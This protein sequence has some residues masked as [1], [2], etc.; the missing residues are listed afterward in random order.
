MKFYSR[1]VSFSKFALSMFIIVILVFLVAMPLVMKD[2]SG[3]RVAFS[4][5]EQTDDA[6]PV[7]EKPQFQGVDKHNRPYLITAKTAQQSG[8]SLILL[9]EVMADVTTQQNEW[10]ALKAKQG[11]LNPE[12]KQLL[13]L[14][15]VQIYHDGG[16]EM[17]TSRV[18]IDLNQLNAFGEK[19]VQIQGPFGHIKSDGFAILDQGDRMLFTSNVE[20]MLFP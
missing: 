13:L 8:D 17:H 9:D 2:R 18:R 14:G 15:D 1:F 5:V 20:V 19:A 16:H 7:M 11:S 10:M 6:P 12:Q 4:S 3:T